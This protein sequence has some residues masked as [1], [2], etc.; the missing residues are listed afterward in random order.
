MT[1][2]DSVTDNARRFP[3]VA[4][5]RLEDREVTHASLRERAARLISAMASAGGRR[6]DGITI[7]SRNSV[8]LGEVMAAC[9]LSGIIMVT[10]NFRLTRDEVRDALVRVRH[11]IVFVVDVF[12]PMVSE[13]APELQNQP[14]IVCIGSQDHCQMVDFDDFLTSGASGAAKS[15]ILGQRERRHVAFTMNAEMRTGSADRAV[16]IKGVSVNRT[17][18]VLHVVL[19]RADKHRP[20]GR[21]RLPAS[22]WPH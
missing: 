9:Q 14:L 11:S 19:D 8:E 5:Y 10:L 6:Q 4:A 17:S 22:S 7:L 1:L 13:L 3:D 2:A 20:E 18:A 15:C 21:L 12:A 16:A